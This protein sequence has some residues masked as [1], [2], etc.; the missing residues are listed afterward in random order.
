[1]IH[2]PTIWRWLT[3]TISGDGFW[4]GFTASNHWLPRWPAQPAPHPFSHWVRWPRRHCGTDLIDDPCDDRYP[5]DNP[6]R[7]ANSCKNERKPVNRRTMENLYS[8]I[9]TIQMMFCTWNKDYCF[10]I[11]CKMSGCANGDGHQQLM[12][13]SLRGIVAA[14]SSGW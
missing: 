13:W 8:K 5:Q 3:E 4:H 10:P 6:W 1:M 14:H 12:V 9:W 2:K 11:S 7:L